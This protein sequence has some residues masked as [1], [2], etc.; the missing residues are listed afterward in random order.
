MDLGAEWLPVCAS[1]R[2]MTLAERL[3]TQPRPSRQQSPRNP[4]LSERADE[5]ISLG[6]QQPFR[7]VELVELLADTPKPHERF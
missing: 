6:E 1:A 2:L 3:T 7:S 4:E 5:L